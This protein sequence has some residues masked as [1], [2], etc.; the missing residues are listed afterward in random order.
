MALARA[1]SDIHKDE[2]KKAQAAVKDVADKT[3]EEERAKLLN[4]KRQDQG[5]I[6]KGTPASAGRPKSYLEMSEEEWKASQA[7]GRR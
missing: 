4:Q 5:P 7:T 1:V 2:A 3:R 6:D